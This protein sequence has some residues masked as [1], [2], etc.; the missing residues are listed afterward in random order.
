MVGR[1]AFRVGVL[2][3]VSPGN[4]PL[5]IYQGSLS[6]EHGKGFFWGQNAFEQEGKL[7]GGIAKIWDFPTT[8]GALI[9]PIAPSEDWGH[10]PAFAITGFADMA[11][12]AGLVQIGGEEAGFH[13]D[14]SSFV[15]ICGEG[16][17]RGSEAD[18]LT[19]A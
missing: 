9:S 8:S 10:A 6:L 4:E 11:M 17:G 14:L 1:Q 15:V 5:K 7:V 18:S 2:A 12:D 19:S 13:Q 3:K 16:W